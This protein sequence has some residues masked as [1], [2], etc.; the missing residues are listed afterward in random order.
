VKIVAKCTT[1]G[2]KVGLKVGPTLLIN[3]NYFKSSLNKNFM[4]NFIIL[5]IINAR[6]EKTR[7]SSTSNS[8]GTVN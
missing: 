2:L 7:V 6:R 8:S 3:D 5:N 1:V 4:E